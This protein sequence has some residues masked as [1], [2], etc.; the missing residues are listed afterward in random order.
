M[1]TTKNSSRSEIRAYQRELN[2]KGVNPPLVL[3]GLWGPKTEAAHAEFGSSTTST[4]D[5]T[6]TPSALK[7]TGPEGGDPRFGLA[8]GAELWKN[9]TTGESYIV[10]VVPGTEDDPVYMRWTIADEADV[11]SFFGPGQPIKYNREVKDGDTIWEE[12]IDFGG[13]DDIR[14]TSK[15]PFDSWSSTLETEAAAQPWLLD[16]DYQQ[17]LAMSVIEGRELTEAEIQSTRWWSENNEAQRQWMLTYHS[18]PSQA[19]QLIDDERLRIKDFLRGQGMEDPTD[20][21]VNF[22]AERTVTGAWSDEELTQQIRILTDPYFKDEAL[23]GDLQD[24]V[25]DNDIEFSTLSDKE[26]EVRN[27]VKRWL[28]TNFGSWSNEMVS[29]WAG[30]LRNEPDAMENLVETLKDQRFALFP[31]Y[32]RESDYD[33]ISA[34]W[35]TVMRNLWGELPS[36]SD[37][38]LQKVIKMND[39]TEANRYLVDEGM[40]RGNQNVK[41]RVQNDLMS[42]FGGR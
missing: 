24:F 11:Q 39:A 28:G 14:N 33:T 18:D 23:D 6:D 22:L 34:P 35:K 25:D 26:I 4:E 31:E 15:N 2:S 29:D 8:G 30:R 12:T 7:G 16:D 36:D 5:E 40:K 9:T 17:L 3:D 41:N 21:L 27:T 37:M 1:A 32:D 42:A 20:E 19:T 13:S 38:E 10:Y